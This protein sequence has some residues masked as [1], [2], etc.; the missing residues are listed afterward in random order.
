MVLLR[1]G[2]HLVIISNS[3]SRERGSWLFLR[4][5]LCL[6]LVR[7]LG[8]LGCL[9]TQPLSTFGY[10]LC[11]PATHLAVT[12]TNWS[13]WTQP[14]GLPWVS[15]VLS[16]FQPPAWLSQEPSDLSRL[17]SDSPP[18]LLCRFSPWASFRTVHALLYIMHLFYIV[19][20]H[21]N[22]SFISPSND[23]ILHC[24]ILLCN[25][26]SKLLFQLQFD[27]LVIVHCSNTVNV[28]QVFWTGNKKLYQSI[29][30][31][32]HNLRLAYFS[33]IRCREG[34]LVP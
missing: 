21:N 10:S 26:C 13:G 6:F 24:S 29:N 16:V 14:D 30:T 33:C 11:C 20:A 1:T 15:L 25:N 27:Y 3:S 34:L 22:H 31:I 32:H 5:S 9:P 8:F 17:D 18:W 2:S 12:R 19:L 23:L 7:S 28:F 4:L